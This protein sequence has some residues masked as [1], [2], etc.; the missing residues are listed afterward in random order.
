[1]DQR[2]A[3]K[4]RPPAE[5]RENTSQN[6]V[7]DIEALRKHLGIDK[8]LVFGGSWGSTL[9]L[10]YAEAHPE[11]VKALILRGIFTL[12]RKELVWTYQEGASN[13]FP[14]H[15]EEFVSVIPEVERHDMISAYHRRLTGNDKKEQL[16]CAKAW[17]RWELATSRLHIDSELLSKVDSDEW[18]LQFARIECN[19]FVN[20]GFFESENQIFDNT[21]KIQNIPT[22]II[23][24]RYDIVC[25]MMSA[26]ELHKVVHVIVFIFP[27]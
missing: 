22:T 19:Y 26:W 5:L 17:S 8:W 13:V 27:C 25:P 24:G 3:G 23:Q 4:S 11:R 9:S 16:K 15:F 1:M 6:L 20:G 21:D 18:A 14:D 10:L 2:G 12:R 7:A